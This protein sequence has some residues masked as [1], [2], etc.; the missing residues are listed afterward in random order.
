M[1]K[2]FGGRI[3]RTYADSSAWG[4]PLP[5]YHPARAA[6]ANGAPHRDPSADA[7]LAMARQ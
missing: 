6:G 2:P 4:P 3:G 1:P 5:E 7:C